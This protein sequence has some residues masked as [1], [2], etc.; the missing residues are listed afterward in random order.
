MAMAVKGPAAQPH[1][2]GMWAA[3]ATTVR[4]SRLPKV[5]KMRNMPST[6]PASPMRLTMKAF[7]PASAALCL[8][9]QK[10]MSR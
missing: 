3:W 1:S 8:W 5:M 6:N 10:P 9:N 2:T 4:K 7:L